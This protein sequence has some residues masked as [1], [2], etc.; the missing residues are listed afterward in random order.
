LTH[1]L[2]YGAFLTVVDILLK[3]QYFI[4]TKARVLICVDC[5]YAVLADIKSIC[6]HRLRT[7]HKIITDADCVMVSKLLNDE[8]QRAHLMSVEDMT[9]CSF[10]KPTSQLLDPIY[11]IPIH[12]GFRCELC[13]DPVFYSTSKKNLGTHLRTTHTASLVKENY[14]TCK[15]QR[16]LLRAEHQ[17]W[18]GVTVAEDE[19]APNNADASPSQ[20]IFNTVMKMVTHQQEH[21]GTKSGEEKYPEVIPF[22]YTQ[23]NVQQF[24]QELKTAYSMSAT[25][26]PQLIQHANAEDDTECRIQAAC[27]KYMQY[28]QQLIRKAPY[29]VLR[30]LYTTSKHG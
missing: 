15:V 25:D 27:V 16:L 9:E 18:F 3:H 22:V 1:V 17:N 24:Q 20:Q 4:N 28:S 14:T 26:A 8:E 21:N 6:S 29:H 30:A 13:V 2:G 23:L 12:D 19:D 7:H 5:N 10:L 11:G